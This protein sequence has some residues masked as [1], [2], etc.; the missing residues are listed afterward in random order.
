MSEDGTERAI[1]AMYEKLNQMGFDC[2]AHQAA[3]VYIAAMDATIEH[4]K[5]PRQLGGSLSGPGGPF[6]FGGVVIDASRALIVDYQEIAK[7]DPESAADQQEAFACMFAGRIN[8]TPDRASVM[9]L[10]NI[11]FMAATIT[12]MHGVAERAGLQRKLHEACE[13]RWREMPHDP[14][15]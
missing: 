11:D 12:E 14:E 4:V 8:K 5:D 7:I 2:N 13:R 15:L 1:I 10:G 6:D 9:L 3:E